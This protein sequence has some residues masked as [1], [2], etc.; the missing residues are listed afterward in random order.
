MFQHSL[1][2][3]NDSEHEMEGGELSS[4]TTCGGE[5]SS[6]EGDES[7]YDKME[8]GDNSEYD[9]DTEIML[10]GVET[11]VNN[12]FSENQ[13]MLEKILKNMNYGR[14]I[15]DSMYEPYMIILKNN[16]NN[17]TFIKLLL[18]L[19][20]KHAMIRLTNEYKDQNIVDIFVNG[21]VDEIRDNIKKIIDEQKISSNATSKICEEIKPLLFKENEEI[22]D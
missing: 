2:Y 20:K 18:V 6:D 4:V 22:K 21:N 14:D 16:D 10:G 13:Y 12:S 17:T 7:E 19:Y 8:G 3:E 9:T 5:Y 11:S 1:F 15:K